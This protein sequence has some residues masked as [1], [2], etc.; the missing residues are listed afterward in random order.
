[1]IISVRVIPNSKKPEITELGS[2]CY[3]I[4]VDAPASD[5]KANARL[6]EILSDYFK[7]PKSSIRIVK[8][9]KSKNKL[10]DIHKP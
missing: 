3:K 5:G 9:H 7:I 4:K 2:N 8:G 1:M 6:I 10:V